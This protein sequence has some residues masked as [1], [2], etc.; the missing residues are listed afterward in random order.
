MKKKKSVEYRHR[1]RVL[2]SISFPSNNS[3]AAKGCFI[4]DGDHR[5]LTGA[6]QTNKWNVNRLI[7]FQSSWGKF[8]VACLIDFTFGDRLCVGLLIGNELLSLSDYHVSVSSH[9]YRQYVID[10]DVCFR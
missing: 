10:A 4:H 7:C 1:S 6:N 3:E 9:V 8:H 5:F 2:A